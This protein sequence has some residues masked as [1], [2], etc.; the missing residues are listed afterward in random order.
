MSVELRNLKGTRDFI[1]GEQRIRNEII[2][3]LQQ[4]FENYGY[5]PIETPIICKYDIL[6]SKYAGGDEILKEV[7]KFKDQGQRDIGLRYDLTVPFARVVGMNP[8]IKMPFKRYEI[9][10]VFRNGPVK[11]GRSREFIQCDVDMVGVKS[12]LAET[13]LM[14]MASDI[15]KTLG[16]DVYISF[17]NRKLLSGIIKTIGVREELEGSVILSLDKLEKIGK[18]GVRNELIEKGLM[19]EDIEK[20]FSL[21]TMNESDL[22]EKLRSN[23]LNELIEQGIK[24]L[25][26]LL[27]YVESLG[28]KDICRFTPCLARG[29]EI[30]TG[31][32]FE[33]FLSDGSISSSLSGG[34]RYDKIIGAFL[35][36]GNEY[37]AVGI[38]FGLDVIYSALEAKGIEIDSSPVQVY[39]I[40]LGTEIESLGL[41]TRLRR[42]GISADIEMDKRKLR[43]SL[44]Y[45]GKQEIPFVIV[46]GEDEIKN[47]KVRIKNMKESTDEEIDIDKIEFFFK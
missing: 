41:L 39:I 31:T 11:T 27:Y 2:R 28:I 7:Y 21:L 23:P 47:G 40:P 12:M 36:N 24:E 1:K 46:I 10:K 16:L 30:Y 17:N 15:Y 44:E 33:I 20:L 3:K 26:E 45:A 32:V 13:E 29:L 4:I 34:G 43:K 42:Q 9:G 38:T 22:L 5:Q 18:D 8:N 19:D 35:N 14:I 37:P 6:A 25:D